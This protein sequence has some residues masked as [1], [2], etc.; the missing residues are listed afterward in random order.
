MASRGQR[1]YGHEGG[2]AMTGPRIEDRGS[3]IEDRK[4][5]IEDR[6]LG[7]DSIHDPRSAI[8]DPRVAL[9]ALPAPAYTDDSAPGGEI[10]RALERVAKELQWSEE[11]RGPFGRMIPR[12]ARVLIKPNLVLHENEG[13][14]GIE[15]LVTHQS[16]I[17]AV[18]EGALRAGP[19]EVLVGDAPLQGCDFQRLLSVTGLG[20]WAGRLARLE[21]TF[22]GV[23][24]F[25]RTTC[26][27]V[28]GVRLA[29]ESLQPEERFILFDL[30]CDS[31][32]E[33]VADGRNSF[34]V[35]CYDPRLLA[36]THAPGR[37][38]YL[39]AKEII[40]ADVIINLPK[41]KTHKKAG[42]TCALK[43]LIGINGNKEYLPH[44]RLGGASAGGDC[45][46]GKSLVKRATEYAL[47]RQNEARSPIT[48]KLWHGA[49]ENL[50]RI[51]SRAGDQIGVE[52]SW[53]G[54]DTV[55]RTGLDLN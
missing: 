40:E 6:G 3:R 8:R 30:G 18:V 13:P 20:E 7:I 29:A 4:L 17:S 12:G 25:R 42:I 50:G 16:L 44:H 43:N 15:P 27:F 34:R 41:L 23:R 1:G 26:V 52:G 21:P 11:E 24:D 9:T 46:P 55:W 51:S 48:G 53:S 36:K 22:K 38:Q 32:L 49:A 39:V 28:N 35:T 31:L 47:D 37:H 19:S 10:R 14:W 33:P 5:R 45:Y 54:N 2:I